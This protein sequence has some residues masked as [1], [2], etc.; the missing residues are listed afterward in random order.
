[1]ANQRTDSVIRGNP[2]PSGIGA[3]VF[4]EIQGRIHLGGELI[5]LLGPGEFLA[6]IAILEL[7]CMGGVTTLGAL[8]G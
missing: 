4:Y 6:L 3:S 1:M 8:Q 7:T 5:M 2:L